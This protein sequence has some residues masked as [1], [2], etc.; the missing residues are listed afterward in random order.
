MVHPEVREANRCQHQL[1]SRITTTGYQPYFHQPPILYFLY[2]TYEVSSFYE[3][4]KKEPLRAS[5]G[6]VGCIKSCPSSFASPL[7]TFCNFICRTEQKQEIS[8]LTPLCP[9]IT[10]SFPAALFSNTPGVYAF[11]SL[12]GCSADQRL[13]YFQYLRHCTHYIIQL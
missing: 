12:Q 11:V 3:D 5:S 6:I 2:L 7:L 4:K 13:E 9:P 1:N 8:F 10:N